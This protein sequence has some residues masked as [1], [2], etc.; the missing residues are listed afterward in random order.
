M[1]I[2]AP[3]LTSDD[4]GERLEARIETDGAALPDILAF[5]VD[6]GDAEAVLSSRLEPLA[7]VLLPVAM[8]L[9]EDIRV[10]GPL[11]PRLADRA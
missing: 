3:R 8:A 1:R 2:H 4:R 9:G 11:S 10:E 6:R 7:I 5:E